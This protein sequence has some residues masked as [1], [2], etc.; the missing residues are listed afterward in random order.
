MATFRVRLRGEGPPLAS[1]SYRV[2]DYEAAVAFCEA[3]GWTDGLPVVPPTAERIWTMLDAVGRPPT[4]VVGE[5]ASRRRRV[6]VEKVAVNA[7]MAGCDP[8][9]FP[10][11]LAAVEALF[12]PAFGVHGPTASTSGQGILVVA[13]GPA[14][15]AG[16]LNAGENLFGPGPRSKANLTVGRA[17]RLVLINALGTVPGALDRACF[18]HPGKIA[19]CIAED[20][21]AVAGRAGWEPLAQERGVPVGRSA[22]TLFAGEAPHQVANGSAGDPEPL[23]A[24]VADVMSAA[25]RLNITGSGE[26]VVLVAAEHRRVLWKAGWTKLDVRRFLHRRAGR[27]LA[28]LK[29]VGRVT[30]AVEA[31]DEG[32]WMPAAGSPDDIHVVAAG[33]SVGGY[34]VVIPGWTGTEH[35]RAVTHAF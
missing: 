3:R 34:T 30:G 5:V 14:A 15:A 2:E 27:T 26:Y 33:G 10:V 23:L 25:G 31:A 22:V 28:D 4:E 35:C 32:R 8:S 1:A 21:A 19:Y 7:V 16:G 18:G 24:S 9:A 13:S 12:E 20:E 17:L 6:T 11:V 29:R